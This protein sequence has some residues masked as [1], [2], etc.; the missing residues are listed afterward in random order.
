MWMH[1]GIMVFVR[2]MFKGL[3]SSVSLI[4]HGSEH[5]WL[6]V[7]EQQIVAVLSFLNTCPVF[8]LVY[9][10]IKYNIKALKKSLLASRWFCKSF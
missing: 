4:S 5:H 2:K 9:F 7:K 6:S 10:I 3:K 8:L 1:L